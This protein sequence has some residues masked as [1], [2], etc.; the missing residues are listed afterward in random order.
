MQ[1]IRWGATS[2]GTTRPIN[3]LL[4]TS[5]L[6]SSNAVF[7]V[8][9]FAAEPQAVAGSIP[10]TPGPTSETSCGLIVLNGTATEVRLDPKFHVLNA[11]S[12]KLPK[13]DPNVM[14]IVCNRDSIIPV[15]G[16]ERVVQG[17]P[18]KF[19]INDGT[20]SGTLS[21]EKNKYK[22]TVSDGILSKP[23]KLAVDTQVKAMQERAKKLAK[24]KS[25]GNKLLGC[26]G[27]GLVTG[28][29]AGLLAPKRDRGA[30][31][32]VGFAAG[33]AVGWSF[34]KNWSEKDKQGLEGASQEA[35]N[36]QNGQMGWQAPESGAQ[37]SFQTMN[38]GERNEDI[39]FEHLESVQEPPDGSRVVAK[40]FRT[41]ARVA[42]RSSPDNS[43]SDNIIGR[44]NAGQTVEVVGLTPDLQWAM[45]GEDGVIVG[46]AAREGF[47][48]LAQPLRKV[49]TERHF[50]DKGLATQVSAPKRK[51]KARG[52]AAPPVMAAQVAPP[53]DRSQVRTTKIA[54]TTQCKTL[55]AVT[56]QQQDRKTGCNSPNGKWRIA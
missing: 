36:S 10:P 12:I 3:A 7:P 43:A 8:A 39:E 33:C 2:M 1:A 34:A 15:P 9:T 32:V 11:K 45:I 27:G 30:A 55:V 13:V 53:P 37:V 52:R 49:V 28:L 38:A 18:A 46:Y 14:A 17:P 16:D 4:I 42:L 35:L 40:P 24:K 20:R 51:A 22:F 19:V 25:N 50:V 47:T 21:F 41:V 44:F 48:E 56:G 6:A 26:V 31:I 54:A 5:M 23:E 29:L